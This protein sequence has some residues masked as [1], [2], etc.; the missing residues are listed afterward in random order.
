MKRVL[1]AGT[2]SGCGKTTVT[3]ALLC[4]LKSRGIDIA[5]FKC[6]PDYI[7]PMFHR[8]IVGVSSYNLDPFFSS[9]SELRSLLAENAG[10][11]SI[12]EG[13]MGYYDGIGPDGHV[14]TYTVAD[15]TGTPVILVVDAK[16]MYTSAGA[17]L[18][19]FNTYRDKSHIEGVIFNNVT[20]SLYDDYRRIAEEADIHPL[21]FL[22]KTPALSIS[23]RHLGLVTAGEI[24]DI[25]EKLWQL[26]ELAERYIDI[27]GVIDLAGSAPKL[28]AAHHTFKPSGKHVNIAVARDEA[29][30][31]IYQETLSLL[32][33][34][35]AVLKFFSPVND[36]ALPEGTCGL[37]LPGGYPELYKEALSSNSKMRSSISKA[38]SNELPV[39][40][41]CGGFMYLHNSL[42]GFPMAGAIDAQTYRT[43]KLQ[44]F[45]YISLSAKTDN[46]L[47]RA[48][49]VMYAHE[50]HY[51]D[52]TDNGES[53]TAK[54]ARSGFEYSCVHTSKTMYAGFPHLHFTP[55]SAGAFVDKAAE[56]INKG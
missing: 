20:P 34:T 51:Y 40:A 31:F 18:Q 43:D 10:D 17:V 26:G 49:E 56:Y 44:R 33:S 30:C 22:P 2:H 6:G 7:D 13:V 27:S 37:Y 38:I 54:K 9:G 19:G 11:V 25:K 23:S 12:I 4:A 16:G 45:G 5:S 35:G 39:V 50:F 3:C 48:G 15:E 14:G 36:N 41:E 42:D 47:C 52:S 46:L 1:I 21:G 28:N 32:E 29:F 24:E 8:E 53:F 55:S